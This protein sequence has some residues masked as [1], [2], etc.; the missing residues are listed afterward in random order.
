MPVVPVLWWLAAWL[1]EAHP[2][3]PVWRDPNATI[4]ARVA[5]LLPRLT[6]QEKIDQLQ[7]T[8]SPEL[9]GQIERLGLAAYTTQECLH[10]VCQHN[11]TVFP[12][13]ISLAA[14]WNV[15]LLQQVGDA[16]GIESRA[17]RNAWDQAEHNIS[18]A[19]PALTCFSP[20]VNIVRDPRSD[21]S[22]SECWPMPSLCPAGGGGPKRRMVKIQR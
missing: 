8:H 15:D 22:R 4:N 14:T 3:Q 17:A 5:D 11:F 19:P 10:G 20:Q 21:L 7:T 13:S 2:D 18:D 6:L 9:P 12:Q 1:C 16:I